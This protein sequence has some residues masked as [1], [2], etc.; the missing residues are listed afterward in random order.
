MLSPT[1]AELLD[2]VKRLE[3]AVDADDVQAVLQ[4]REM[5]LAH[6]MEPLQAFDELML[7]QLSKASSTQQFLE[8]TVGLSPGDAHATVTMARKLAAMP[9]TE[10]GWL[11]GTL[12]SGQVRAVMGNVSK[13]T[14]EQYMAEEADVLAIIVPLDAKDTAKAMQSWAS[15]ANALVDDDPERPPREDEFFHSET[16]GGRYVSN[17]NFGGG[18]R[19]GDRQGHRVGRDRQSA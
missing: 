7:Y 6:T 5:L 9:L 16:T 19:F 15:Y 1:V 17:G 13:R 18:D 10:A 11:A 14:A 3:M 8:R 4:A 2:V 12:S